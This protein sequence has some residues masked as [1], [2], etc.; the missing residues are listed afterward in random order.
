MTSTAEPPS[1]SAPATQRP[2]GLRERKKLKTKE[3]IQRE[4][5]R[6]FEE[7]GYEE[8]TIEAIAAAAEISPSTFFNYFPTKEDVVLFDRYDPLMVSLMLAGPS[9]EP[10][11][12]TIARGIDGLGPLV[13]SDHALVLARAKLG[14]KVPALRARF[15]EELEKAQALLGGVFAKHTGRDEA[16]FEVRVLSMMLVTASFE[17][18]LEW[19]HRGGEGNMFEVVQEALALSGVPARLDAL[20]R[21]SSPK[22][23]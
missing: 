3:T 13:A 7:R 6:L 21:T 1:R 23:A 18:L 14:L 10:L 11:S 9:D 22:P 19:L 12:A 20:Q 5:M 16:D 2:L 17:G 4:A 8:T 15:W